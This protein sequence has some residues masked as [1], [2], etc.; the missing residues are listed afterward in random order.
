MFKWKTHGSA[1]S[2]LAIGILSLATTPPATAALKGAIFTTTSTGAVV[3]G[4][5]YAAKQDVYLS[6]GPQNQNASGLPDGAYYFQVT[7]PSG[8]TLLSTDPITCRTLQVVN[9][10]V[11]GGASCTHANGTLDSASGATPVQLFPFD[12]TRIAVGSTRSG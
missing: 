11:S 7:D 6:G 3:N 1:F 12:D 4:N 8:K 2:A 5:I 9:G 10:R